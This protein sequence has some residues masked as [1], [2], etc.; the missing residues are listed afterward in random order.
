MFTSQAQTGI[1]CHNESDEIMFPT[2]F[3]N[4]ILCSSICAAGIK[5]APKDALT[6]CL[7]R[8]DQK[9]RR[10]W[11]PQTKSVLETVCAGTSIPSTHTWCT[12]RYSQGTTIISQNSPIRCA[13]AAHGDDLRVFIP[14][15][16]NIY[17]SAQGEAE[18]K[19]VSLRG[20][21][22]SLLQPPP[23]RWRLQDTQ[24][25]TRRHLRNHGIHIW[26]VWWR[27]YVL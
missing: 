7:S 24:R 2:I 22:P 14:A 21:T 8:H 19:N 25:P 4:Q 27:E 20:S 15:R 26:S 5:G 9:H 1:C 3:F 13:L 12:R 23:R 6:C 16:L 18:K 11:Q 10:G 17:F